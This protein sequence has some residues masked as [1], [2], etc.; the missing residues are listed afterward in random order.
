MADYYREQRRE[1]LAARQD[2]YVR[3]QFYTRAFGTVGFFMV[4]AA[5]AVAWIRIYG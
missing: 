5:V 1:W 4:V 2:G 3:V